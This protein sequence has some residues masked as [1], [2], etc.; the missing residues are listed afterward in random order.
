[1]GLLSPVLRNGTD[2]RLTWWCPGCDRAH[3]IQYG[4]GPRPR[5]TWDG[6]AERPTFSPSVLVRWNEPN[7]D[8]EKFDDSAYDVAKVCH[9][10]IRGG[11]I[12]FLPDCT[13]KLA[14]QTVDIPAWP[15]P[16]WRDG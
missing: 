11:R 9:V 13:H 14:G 6:N 7:D 15:Q 2:N 8:P 10:F 3:T 5:W 1:M 12:E 4:E 16:D